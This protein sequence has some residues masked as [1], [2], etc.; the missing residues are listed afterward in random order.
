MDKKHIIDG[1]GPCSADVLVCG[2]SEPPGSEFP[3]SRRSGVSGERH[4]LKMV[5]KNPTIRNEFVKIRAIRVPFPSVQKSVPICADLPVLRPV[6]RSFSEDGS[7]GEAGWLRKLVK[8]MSFFGPRKPLIIKRHQGRSNLVKLGRVTL[9]Q[10]KFRP[11][12]HKE[13][14]KNP[15]N[16]KESQRITKNHSFLKLKQVRRRQ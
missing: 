8:F 5:A 4:Q 16:H 9:K 12:K 15:V 13:T 7:L 11:I 3:P 10:A 6:R 1:T 14:P 2:F